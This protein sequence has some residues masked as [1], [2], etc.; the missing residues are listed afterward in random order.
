M[1]K[2]HKIS[3]EQQKLA[4]TAETCLDQVLRESLD[5]GVEPAALIC[6]LMDKTLRMLDH[7]EFDILARIIGAMALHQHYEYHV[8]KYLESLGVKHT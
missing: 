1:E 8:K 2:D 6:I 4:N 7:K 5:S 3:Q